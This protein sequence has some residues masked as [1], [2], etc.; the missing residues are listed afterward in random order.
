[1]RVCRGKVKR[2]L[3]PSF[4][5]FFWRNKPGFVDDRE[6]TNGH[7]WWWWLKGHDM[8]RTEGPWEAM[9]AMRKSQQ[10]HD[11]GMQSRLRIPQHTNTRGNRQRNRIPSPLP[12]PPQ[13]GDAM[14]RCPVPGIICKLACSCRCI[15]SRSLYFLET[16][17]LSSLYFAFG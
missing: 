11:M 4:F 15:R 9:G 14:M 3:V 10:Q 7:G 6:G 17:P 5:F 1:M 2:S 8:E 12:S 16:N 13:R